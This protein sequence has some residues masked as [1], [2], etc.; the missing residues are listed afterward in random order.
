MM[1][2]FISW[3][4]QIA[5]V[6]ILVGAAKT[7]SRKCQWSADKARSRLIWGVFTVG[8][9]QVAS[10]IREMMEDKGLGILYHIQWIGVYWIALA[11]YRR[12]YLREAKRAAG[13][14]IP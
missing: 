6:F 12:K 3:I 11:S 4:I 2:Y 14:A 13:T 9:V 8:F 1:R 5:L 7:N 10:F